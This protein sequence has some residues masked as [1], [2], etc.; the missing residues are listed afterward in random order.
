MHS[1]AARTGPA[2]ILSCDPIPAVA[3]AGLELQSGECNCS[4]VFASLSFVLLLPSPEDPVRMPCF[5][6]QPRQIFFSLN[7]QYQSTGTHSVVPA[8]VG[9]GTRT[10]ARIPDQPILVTQP[11]QP[12]EANSQKNSMAFYSMYYCRLRPDLSRPTTARNTRVIL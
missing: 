12:D 8:L 1:S 3:A 9:L 2:A 11:R 7:F 5:Q 6:P 4:V 10:G